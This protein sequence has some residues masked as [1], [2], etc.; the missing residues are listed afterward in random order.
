LP[1]ICYLYCYTML[2]ERGS[3]VGGDATAVYDQYDRQRALHRHSRHTALAVKG[4]PP[5]S[6]P[7]RTR[8]ATRSTVACL[9]LAKALSNMAMGLQ[10]AVIDPK[11][12]RPITPHGLR[13]TF[14]SGEMMLVLPGIFSKNQIGTA[15]ERAYRRTDG[16]ERR[17]AVMVAASVLA[18]LL[19]QRS[20]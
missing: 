10:T 18:K 9:R 3:Y 13:A 1:P 16:F 11:G 5:P 8:S 20:S 12:G 14:R 2:S 15:V 19:C 7:L 6:P 4:A 17:R